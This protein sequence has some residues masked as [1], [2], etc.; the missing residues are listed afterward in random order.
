MDKTKCKKYKYYRVGESPFVYAG[1]QCNNNCFFCFEADREFPY[2]SVSELKKEIRIIR[3]NFDFINFMGQ[4]PTLRKDIVEL[5]GYAKDLKFKQIGL[6]TNG[7]MFVYT[8]FVKNILESGLNQIV[9]T[10]AGRDSKTHDLHT[11]AKGSFEQA[12]FG[13]KN[14][15][16]FKKSD[17]SFV[18][19]IMITQKNY[20]KLPVMVDFYAN[21]GIKEINIGHIMPLNKKVRSSKAVVA[22]LSD[23]VPLLIKCQNKYKSKI[24]F[25]FVEYPACVFP[26]KYQNLSFPCLEENP[27]KRRIELCRDCRYNKRCVGIHKAYL[28]LYGDKEFK[29]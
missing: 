13:I 26:K 16:K 20:Q 5:I 19:N 7:R 21:L 22:Q 14:I 17:L 29:L 25:L 11:L 28:N 4:E 10:V 23:V 15:L 24:K 6:T 1:Y 8:D 2:K 3:K 18:I 9:L 12:L 27:D